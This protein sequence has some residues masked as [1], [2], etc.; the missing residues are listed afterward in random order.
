MASQRKIIRAAIVTALRNAAITG[1]NVFP[2]RWLP[3]WET[4]LPSI[5]V[6]TDSE[7]A[8]VFSIAPR[9]MRRETQVVTEVIFLADSS[10]DDQLDDLGELI[11]NVIVADPQF[12]GTADDTFL[13]GTVL[14]LFSNGDALMGSLKITWGVRWYKRMPADLS[15]SLPRLGT[16]N[17][18]FDQSPQD[19][20]TDIE[21]TISLDALFPSHQSLFFNGTNHIAIRSGAG[22]QVSPPFALG[23]NATWS[24]WVKPSDLTQARS[25]FACFGLGS[26][27]VGFEVGI[28]LVTLGKLGLYTGSTVGPAVSEDT[29][30]SIATSVWTH[31]AITFDGANV[32]FYKNGVLSSVVPRT[33]PIGLTAAPLFLGAD[34]NQ[35]SI[36]RFVGLGSNFSVFKA[37]LSPTQIAEFYTTTHPMDLRLHS[38][39]FDY[40]VA[41]WQLMGAADTTNEV[42]DLFGN[43]HGAAMHVLSTDLSADVP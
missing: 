32:C 12:A 30:A 10:L 13:K 34:T 31:I 33:E 15:G 19:G 38:A 18:K 6:Y 3:T 17:V 40:G 14:D 43:N 26:P 37:A 1:T 39:A 23:I 4:E 27:K 21:S 16:A 36:R 8:E 29:G 5:F 2:N 35:P 11:E 7:D 42:G 41:W 24:A 28:G 22:Q 9:E 25:L 20:V